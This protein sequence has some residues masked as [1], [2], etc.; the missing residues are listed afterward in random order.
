MGSIFTVYGR[1]NTVQNNISLYQEIFNIYSQKVNYPVLFGKRCVRGICENTYDKLYRVRGNSLPK[2]FEVIRKTKT[3][4]FC[5]RT[6]VGAVPLQRYRPL[7]WVWLRLKIKQNRWG[8]LKKKS[9]VSYQLIAGVQTYG[10][11]PRYTAEN[12][13]ADTEVCAKKCQVTGWWLL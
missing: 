5:H 3:K 9:C 7:N 2:F 8:I 12:D 11:R 1:K 13:A 10:Y 6:N 4:N